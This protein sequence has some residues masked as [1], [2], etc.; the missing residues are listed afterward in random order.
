MRRLLLLGCTATLT[1][2][3]YT[4]NVENTNFVIRQPN[5]LNAT[6]Y[7]F[8]YNRIRLKY[9]YTGGSFFVGA[10]GDRVDYFGYDY[11]HSPDFKYVSSIT[12]DIPFKTRTDIARFHGNATFL[13]LHRLYG[14]YER[15][16]HRVTA[17]IQKISMGV[18]RIWTPTDLYNP[19][20][21]Y[22]YEP[23]EVMGVLALDYAYAP[24]ALSV[25]NAVVSV[26][27]DGTPKYAARYKGYLEVADFG[28]DLMRSD[29]TVM[30]GYEV[31][32]NVFATGAEWR[33][34]G[35]YFKND[36]L[37]TEFFQGILGLDYGFENG[38]SIAVEGL[39][40]SKTFTYEQL[41]ANAENEIVN[42][43]V[44]SPLYLGGT[45]SYDFSLAL[46]GSLLYIESFDEAN[47]RFVAP[48]LSYTAG[49]HNLFSIGAMLGLGPQGS[50]FD[51]YGQ[52]FYLNWQ[53]SY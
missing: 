26:R 43:M 5:L 3:H 30:A 33:S 2:A 48:S 4:V 24:T 12:P 46:G 27:R 16:A 49:D 31:E 38:M 29:E 10:I 20:N 51:H 36:P 17:G 8:D 11:I 47:S 42:N 39:Y 1:L 14:G 7:L 9:A 50:E 28:L 25:V 15:G 37:N 19:K 22:A 41:L 35:G 52:R 34:E 23:D 44:L 32:G 40:S 45:L 53:L 21:A 18:G 6:D 13:K